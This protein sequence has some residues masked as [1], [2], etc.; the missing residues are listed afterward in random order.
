MTRIFSLPGSSEFS[1]AKRKAAEMD[2]ES[3]VE[4]TRSKR[5]AGEKAPTAEQEEP[6]QFSTYY[7]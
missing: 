7:D 5:K 1:T 4:N 6:R 3:P 2:P